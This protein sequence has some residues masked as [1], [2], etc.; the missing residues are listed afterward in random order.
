[1]KTIPSSSYFFAPEIEPLFPTILAIPRG[2]D[3]SVA[4]GDT[5]FGYVYSGTA[6]T[7]RFAIH[8]QLRKGMFF[9]APGPA[10]LTGLTGFVCIR[11]AYRGLPMWGGPIEVQGRL[12]YING[13]SDTLL[14]APAVK[15]DPC[16][17]YLYIPPGIRQTPH[18]HPS[19]RVGCIID[20]AG[21]CVLA[22]ETV[23]L[24]PGANFVLPASELHSFHTSTQ[25]LRVVVYH[26]DSD[27]GPTDEF[28]PMINR[29]TIDNVTLA[30][31]NNTRPQ[32][33]SDL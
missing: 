27:F 1:M 13:C 18:T 6:K 31:D 24:I 5:A 8:Q 32:S 15:G 33:T 11:R 19:V 7:H 25:P 30:S 4:E 21:V 28:H 2:R 22:D 10:Q 26:P 23:D 29:T 3:V 20:G 14:L 9:S 16:L 17:N 12:K